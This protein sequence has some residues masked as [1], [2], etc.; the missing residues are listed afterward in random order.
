MEEM[1]FEPMTCIHW[2]I[3]KDKYY[4]YNSDKIIIY[5]I[6]HTNDEYERKCNFY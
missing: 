3:L 6:K 1:G 2:L 4:K 5:V